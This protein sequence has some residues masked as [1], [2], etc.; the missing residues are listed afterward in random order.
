M[1]VSSSMDYLKAWSS[2][3]VFEKRGS[4]K[5]KFGSRLIRSEDYCVSTVGLNEA[6]I[7]KYIREWKAHDQAL[8]TPLRE[9]PKRDVGYCDP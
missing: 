2:L 5:C 3:M 4:L 9:N 8:D 6:M 1:S 7:A